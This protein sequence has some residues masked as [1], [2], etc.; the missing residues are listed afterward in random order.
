M[1]STTW[2]PRTTLERRSWLLTNGEVVL[3]PLLEESASGRKVRVAG[4]SLSTY[5]SRVD[6]LIGNSLDALAKE[7]STAVWGRVVEHHSGTLGYDHLN[8]KARLH[9]THNNEAGAKTIAWWSFRHPTMPIEAVLTVRLEA[10]LNYANPSGPRP[11][12]VKGTLV[13]PGTLPQTWMH[14]QV[15]R[16]ENASFT[17]A[18]QSLPLHE[19]QPLVDFLRDNQPEWAN[20]LGAEGHAQER[21]AATELLRRVQAVEDLDRICIPDL[22]DPTNPAWLELELQ[23]SNVTGEFLSELAEY[24]A[25]APTVGEA[26]KLYTDLLRTMQD[27]G[28]VMA[29]RSENDFLAGLLTGDREALSV[30]LGP[31]AGDDEEEGPVDHHHTLTLHLPTG[32]L[33][34]NCGLRHSNHGDIAQKW[35]EVLTVAQLTG[36]EDQLLGY[37]QQHVQRQT[38]RRTKRILHQRTSQNDDQ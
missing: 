23:D 13:H 19:R 9:L 12:T 29:G 34:V 24:V 33:I 5:A 18:V 2:H 10:G 36:R 8:T 14:P 20:V 35:D 31:C 26:A 4:T 11:Q 38:E 30:S 22:R 37:A 1:A 27:L 32:T 25:S 28:M 21:P 3:E 16:Q 6:E 17:S 15:Y 7:R